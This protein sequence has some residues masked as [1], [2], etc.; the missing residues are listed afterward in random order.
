MVKNNPT[1]FSALGAT[2]ADSGGFQALGG[3][4]VAATPAAPPATAPT[5]GILSPIG[6][7]LL[8]QGIGL[9]LG[10]LQGAARLGRSVNALGLAAINKIFGSHLTSP[11]ADV[12][13]GPLARYKGT[14]GAH[15]GEFL[16]QL[17]GII[18]GGEAFAPAKYAEVAHPF[19]KQALGYGATAFAGTPGTLAERAEHAVEALP[20]PIPARLAEA[21]PTLRLAKLHPKLQEIWRDVQIDSR[22][23]YRTAFRGTEKLPTYLSAPSQEM[24][25][26]LE[27]GRLKSTMVKDAI[28]RYEGRPNP[29]GLHF[30]KSDLGKIAR[31]IKEG[32]SSVQQDQK[33]LLE[34]LTGRV[35]PDTL[36]YEPG[37]LAGDLDFTMELTPKQNQWA[38]KIAQNH[39]RKNIVPVKQMRTIYQAL[40]APRKITKGIYGSFA[41]R[42][43]PATEVRRIFG[44]PRGRAELGQFLHRTGYWGLPAPLGLAALMGGAY[45]AR[46]KI[47]KFISD[48]F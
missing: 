20:L 32:G 1:D 16:A 31:S 26:G 6:R 37:T 41:E 4:P 5:G 8:H 40:R 45:L 3:T 36:K 24:L 35:N 7:E 9:Q 22:N 34:N 28:R 29:E 11:G 30:L 43:D 33:Y 12:F 27:S 15:V 23:L 14:T 2:P 10:L 21:L 44:I 38:Y 46:D 19:I 25:F 17:G 42:S 47:A 48:K 13:F 39:Y 18:A